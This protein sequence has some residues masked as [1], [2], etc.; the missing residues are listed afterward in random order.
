MYSESVFVTVVVC[1][2]FVVVAFYC[3]FVVV[4]VFG[5]VGALAIV[6]DYM[7][8]VCLFRYQLL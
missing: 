5:G 4:V 3:V 2:V 6:L 1:F 8:F 7:L